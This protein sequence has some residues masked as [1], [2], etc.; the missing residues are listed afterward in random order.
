MIIVSRKSKILFSIIVVLLS[1][2]LFSALIYHLY[3]VGKVQRKGLS[4]IDVSKPQPQSKGRVDSKAE[5]ATG[6]LLPPKP[7]SPDYRYLKNAA[8]VFGVKQGEPINSG[9]VFKDGVYLDAP[10]VV[11]RRGVEVYVN[12][13]KVDSCQWPPEDWEDKMPE[14]PKEFTKNTTN[15]VLESPNY[16][17]AGIMI[18]WA[19]RHYDEKK[20]KEIVTENYKKLPFIKSVE[21]T[22]DMLLLTTW[23]G[24]TTAVDLLDEFSNQIYTPPTPEQVWEMTEGCRSNWERRL[25]KG[26]CYFLFPHGLE[27]SLNT[28]K[29]ATDL[30]IIIGVLQSNSPK[31]QKIKKLQ[32]YTHF[33]P[34]SREWDIFIDKFSASS[35]LDERIKQL[36]LKGH[37]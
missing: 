36:Q 9:F 1:I 6:M 32:K 28:K 10:Y 8:E 14:I 11:S 16:P 24:G 18:R 29:A 23:S 2:G 25:K 4:D 33:P 13:V 35:Q 15:E 12:N 26:D 31:D 5:S 19:Q 7:G 34:D 30:A 17:W 37:E 22:G 27:I 20:A 21:R 3:P